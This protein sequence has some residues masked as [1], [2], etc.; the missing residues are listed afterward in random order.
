M[1]RPF[2]SFVRKEISSGI[3][4]MAAAAMAML[5]A[6]SPLAHS[7]HAFWHTKISVNIGTYGI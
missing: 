5:W 2:Q 6:N 1:G 7:Y 3:L 4:L